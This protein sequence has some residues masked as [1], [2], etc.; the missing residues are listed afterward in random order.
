MLQSKRSV[1]K[2][3]IVVVRSHGQT[4]G[5][6]RSSSV[7][8]FSASTLDPKTGNGKL[9]EQ[10]YL[11]CGKTSTRNGEKIIAYT[12]EFRVEP[13]F[14]F[15]GAVLIKNQH[16]KQRFFLQSASVKTP[17][18]EIIQFDCNSWVYPVKVTKTS[19]IFFSNNKYLPNQTPEA[20]L[21][22]R[23]KE[24]IG[25][26]GN[27]G[28][29][30]KEW[31]RIYDYDFYNDLGNPDKGPEYIRPVLGGSDSNPYPRRF[32]TSRPPRIADPSTERPP[33]MIDL[34]MNVPPDERFSSK[35]LAE[36]IS[37]SIQAVNYCVI[38]KAESLS[39]QEPNTFKSFDEVHYKY[40]GNRREVHVEGWFQKKLKNV[41]PAKLFKEVA[42]MRK[43]N[44]L[45]FS[46]PQI[47][48]EN[49]WAWKND[50]EFARQMLAG[51]NPARI[52]S[53]EIFPPESQNG[54]MS[55]IRQSDIEHNLDGLTLAQAINQWR[56]FI[57]DHHDYL[58]PFLNR[59]NRNGV[60]GFASRTLLF[61]K[62]DETLKPLVIELSLPGFYEGHEL[63]R[64]FVPAT[65]GEEGAIWQCAKAHVTANDSVYHQLISHWLQTHAVVE[66]F[67]IAT[68]RQLSVMHPVHW[69]LHP[70]FKDTLHV[71]ALARTILIKS[72]GILEKT[73]FSAE[74]SMELSAELYKEWR[75]DE[76]ALPVDLLKRGMAIED[77][78]P[79][80]PTG[81]KLLIKDYPYGADG[82]EIWTVIK[83]WVSDFCTLF[84]AD[85]D[86]VVSDVEVQAWWSEI[87]NVGHGDKRDKTWWYE[88]TTLSDLIE[89]LTT[90]IWIASALHASVNFG[91]YDYAGYPLNRPTLCRRFTPTEGTFAYALFLKDP[92]QY[93]LNM[94]PGR[95]ETSL[96]V[97]LVAVLSCHASDEVYLG[98]RSLPVSI[99]NEEVHQKFEK[100]NKELK[101]IEKRITQRNANLNLKNRRGP[102]GI[103]YQ[104]LYPDT[105]K[106][107][108]RG[109]ITGKG[110]PNSISI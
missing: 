75:F 95:L 60:C 63:S 19:R 104:L 69:L 51:T 103:P 27:G 42:N 3:E 88:M 28:R 100:F 40:S 35:K 67:I 102:A 82:L 94:L 26:K 77:E 52:R 85:D 76:Q 23:K 12:F 6:A 7:Q 30:R 46:S 92:D 108:S 59:I 39:Q 62:S 79:D 89:A 78:D 14:G 13:D 106:V 18:N 41:L 4:S 44:P 90:L 48:A 66:P 10:A 17:N 33:D 11:R 2:G 31:D 55:S 1:I 98:Q 68:R 70:H 36:F 97:A 109:G 105:S 8:I 72:G 24:L 107:E 57:L 21:E 15:P 54:V 87:R 32:R 53:L 99:N 49:E 84:Y 73:L 25:L 64:V 91:Q 58:M 43:K 110:I 86:S 16:K 56:I 47:I 38:Q 9:S 101:E 45:R 81:V 22:L 74:L 93:Y 20:L 29:E 96:S 65:G 80:N 5:S 71:N 83:T 61:Q 50:E 34:D 37:S